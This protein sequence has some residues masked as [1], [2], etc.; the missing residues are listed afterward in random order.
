MSAAAADLWVVMVVVMLLAPVEAVTHLHT[1]NG[2]G[3]TLAGCSRFT[4]SGGQRRGLDA[5]P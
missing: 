1:N 4:V 5:E 3:Q 2:R